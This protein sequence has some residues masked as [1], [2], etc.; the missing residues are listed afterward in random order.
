[1]NFDNNASVIIEVV[2]AKKEVWRKT[3]M[4]TIEHLGDC[5]KRHASKL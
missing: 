1:M 4:E 2:Q 3:G 5:L